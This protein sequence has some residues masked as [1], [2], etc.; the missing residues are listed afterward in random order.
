MLPWWFSGR[1]PACNAGDPGSIPGL[2]WSPGGG[3]GNPL[4]FSCLE[5]PMGREPGRL[6]TWGSHRVRQDW[7]DFI[8][9][10]VAYHTKW[11]GGSGMNWEMGLDIIY[12]TDTKFQFS[13]VQWL[14]PV[15]LFATSWD[16]STPGLPCPSP[17][18]GV[19]SNSCPLSRGYHP[20]IS[21]SVVPFSRL[22]S[23]PAS[24]SFPMSPFFPSGGQS[25]GMSA[26]ASV[27]P[28]NIQDWFPL[29]WT[30]LGFHYNS[31][32][33]SIHH[34]WKNHSFE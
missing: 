22:H 17:A 25:I 19:Y 18:P 34:H 27:L 7:S 13:P 15:W 8:G 12:T 5:N 6:Q 20:T 14:S 26:S 23:F 30:A 32:L 21:S 33:T 11:R 9:A 28:M 31:T 1:E 3:H 24:G 16:C 2:G 10:A 29:G 4:M